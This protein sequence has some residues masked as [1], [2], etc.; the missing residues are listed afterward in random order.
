MSRH[1][2]RSTAAGRMLRAALDYASAGIPLVPV[3]TPTPGGGCSCGELRCASAGKHPRVRGG[4]H[5]ASTDPAQ[6]AR[7]WGRWP[8]A[9]IGLRTGVLFD[10]CDVDG[11]DARRS[12]LTLLGP[13]CAAGPLAATG[14]G[15]HLWFAATGT[16]SRARA[17]DGIDWRA[18]DAIVVAPPSRH[19][20][21]VSYR[22]LRDH[23]HPAPA[24]PPALAAL[25]QPER[26]CD[27]RDGGGPVTAPGAY[28]QAALTAE[29]LRVRSAR[30][31]AGGNGGNRNDTLNR[32]A[33]SLGQLV[34]TG[35]LDPSLVTDV[36]TAAALDTG[37]GLAETRRTIASGLRAG[38]HHPRLPPPKHAQRRTQ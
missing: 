31:P 3:H 8:Y 35:L 9:N 16:A 33:F 23:R 27:R 10:V 2:A 19:A 5:A 21:G 36:L 20:T 7:W 30:A 29:T 17:L 34:A 15:W 32:A 13:A 26:P 37:L 25:L 22:W 14:R 18:R 12:L 6:V 28:A 38:Q 1:P 4:V 11:P 24:C